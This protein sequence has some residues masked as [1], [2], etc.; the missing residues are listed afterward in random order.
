MS[1][2]LFTD[3][4]SDYV[5]LGRHFH[6]F[7]EKELGDEEMLAAYNEHDGWS[8][9]L[10]WS[11]LLARKR[12]VIL[13]SAGSGKTEEMVQITKKLVEDKKHA[14][15]VRLEELAGANFEALLKHEDIERLKSWRESASAEAWFLLDSVDELKLT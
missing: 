4:Q 8:R 7:T 6:Q 15:Y 10:S 12:V 2:S 14:F 13:A 11:D 1:Q 5:E 3:C 9:S